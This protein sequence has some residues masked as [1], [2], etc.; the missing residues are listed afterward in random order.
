VVV[1]TAPRSC[2]CC[3]AP[4]TATSQETLGYQAFMRCTSV[5]Y[6]L[7]GATTASCSHKL[8]QQTAQATEAVERKHQHIAWLVVVVGT[9]PQSREWCSCTSHRHHPGD[10]LVPGIMHCTIEGDYLA[11]ATTAATNCTKQQHK[12]QRQFRETIHTPPGW[13]WWL[14]QRCNREIALRT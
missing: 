9:A 14:G 12:L 13:W 10:A 2:D 5:A 1:G 3:T 8:H 6:H 7:A 11:G 4:V